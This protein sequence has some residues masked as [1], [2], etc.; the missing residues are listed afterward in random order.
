MLV[1]LQEV[2]VLVLFLL[3]VFLVLTSRHIWDWMA[4]LGLFPHFQKSLPYLKGNSKSGFVSVSSKVTQFCNGG[5]FLRMGI[6]QEY[7]HSEDSIV[8]RQHWV[9]CQDRDSDTSHSAASR[10]SLSLNSLELLQET[11]KE[12]YQVLCTDDMLQY[13]FFSLALLSQF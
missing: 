2:F 6:L 8:C 5:V 13:F 10:F 3:Q 11:S 12:D 4:G 7:V 9:N 1:G